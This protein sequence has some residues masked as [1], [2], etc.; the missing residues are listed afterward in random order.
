MSQQEKEIFFGYVSSDVREGLKINLTYLKPNWDGAFDN[1]PIKKLNKSVQ[2][3]RV[4]Y[5]LKSVK[6]LVLIK[7]GNEYFLVI[8]TR[9]GFE[10]HF[11]YSTSAPNKG[12]RYMPY[13]V[14]NLYA[15]N[16]IT[17]IRKFDGIT[18]TGLLGKSS[19]F[20]DVY[21]YYVKNVLYVVHVKRDPLFLHQK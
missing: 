12:A 1:K 7:S 20:K 14:R 13:I 15:E 10:Y 4:L 6:S 11:G 3:D 21:M 2:A 9:Y 19:P 18:S 8:D 17:D 5:I 16:S